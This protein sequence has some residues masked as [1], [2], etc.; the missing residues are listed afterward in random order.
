M[1]EER[2]DAGYDD[3]VRPQ[4]I[5]APF[6]RA[7]SINGD[8]VLLDLDRDEYSCIPGV[9]LKGS[10]A[11][12]SPGRLPADL[13]ALLASEGMVVDGVSAP[14]PTPVQAATERLHCAPGPPPGL[15]DLY[16]VARAL[17]DLA[18]TGRDAPVTRLLRLAGSGNLNGDPARVL[19]AAAVFSTLLP[20]LPVRGQ[21]LHRSALL[22]RFLACKGLT[23]DWMFGVRTWPFEAHCWVQAGAL[24][25]NDEPE[26]LRAF[27][28][29]FSLLGAASPDPTRPPERSPL[30]PSDPRHDLCGR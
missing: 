18:R 30:S 7:A 12:A 17:F 4:A 26:H 16:H 25:L 28:V 1:T 29:L 8:I 5:F 6:V 2:Q 23:A 14:P 27:A 19:R 21:C 11:L 20:W 13:V 22:M 15:A 10:G 9:G 3:A 24:C